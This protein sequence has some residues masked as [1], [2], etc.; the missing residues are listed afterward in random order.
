M[1]YENE[2]YQTNTTFFLRHSNCGSDG[3]VQTMLNTS[4]QRQKP[5]KER[6]QK[7]RVDDKENTG[8]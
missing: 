4:W 7:P 3:G 8:V 6:H 5:A 2:H 1:N